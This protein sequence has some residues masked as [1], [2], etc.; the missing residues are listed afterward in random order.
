VADAKARLSEL[1][2][3][4]KSAPQIIQ[5]RGKSVGVVIGY[6]RY[7]DAERRAELGSAEH[8]MK[9]FLDAAAKLRASGGTEL[10]LP[11]RETRKSP[12]GAR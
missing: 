6:D 2:E 5:R 11:R 9:A 1:V 10:E 12:F 4:A 3:R 8:R 7:V